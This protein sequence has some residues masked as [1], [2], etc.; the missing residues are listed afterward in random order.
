MYILTQKTAIE[1]PTGALYKEDPNVPGF[2][3]GQRSARINKVR[4]DGTPS[5]GTVTSGLPWFSVTYSY[6]YIRAAIQVPSMLTRGFRWLSNK[7]VD[8]GRVIRTEAASAI[9]SMP[10]HLGVG[11]KDKVVNA[12][13]MLSLATIVHAPTYSLTDVLINTLP[14]TA[15][16][17]FGQFA[18]NIRADVLAGSALFRDPRILSIEEDEVVLYIYHV[19][20]ILY[21]REDVI[22]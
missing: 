7:I 18:R 20:P 11:N 5:S 12:Q 8:E 10:N 3:K 17:T 16:A 14:L 4:K 21:L 15:T 13:A 1:D 19:D 9:A 22:K 6:R 2:G